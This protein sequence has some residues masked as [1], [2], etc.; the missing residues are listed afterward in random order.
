M[1]RHGVPILQRSPPWTRQQL[2]A[3]IQRGSHPSTKEHSVFLRDEMA[4]MVAQGHWLVI[5]YSQALLLP[6]LCL[7]P[8]GVV[9]QRDRRPRA[10]VDFTFSGVNGNTLP[11]LAPSDS[12]QFGRALDRILFRIHHANRHF[13]P[14]QLIKVDIADGFYRIKVAASHMPTLSVAFPSA[15]GEPPLVAIPFVLPMGWVSSPPF[16]VLPPKPPPSSPITFWPSFLSVR[17]LT[18]YS[19]LRM[20]LLIFNRS[21]DTFP[22][23]DQPR[24]QSPLH[25]FRLP[26]PYV[27]PDI[28]LH[29]PFVLPG[30]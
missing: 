29:K 5:P 21:P 11:T 13:G 22:V 9:P 18:L 2:D 19:R 7:S 17:L 12:M 6:H 3:A 15:P 16:F 1:A 30:L 24:L 4:D 8:M 26:F 23:F 20:R 27:P 14:V 28:N 25:P 10:I